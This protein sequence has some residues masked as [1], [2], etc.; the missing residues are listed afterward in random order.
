MPSARHI[1]S[2]TTDLARLLADGFNFPFQKTPQRRAT[3]PRLRLCISL[4]H[5][6]LLSGTEPWRKA[7]TLSLSSCKWYPS[8]WQLKPRPNSRYQFGCWPLSCFTTRNSIFP[9]PTCQKPTS[10][11]PHW[12]QAALRLPQG[13]RSGGWS[14]GSPHTGPPHFPHRLLELSYPAPHQWSLQQQKEQISIDHKI[15]SSTIMINIYIYI[16]LNYMHLADIVTA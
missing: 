4:H 9:S 12:W 13:D 14:S 5:C 16:Y 3:C 6:S 7:Q 10:S 1:S 8:K 2:L 11:V 15:S